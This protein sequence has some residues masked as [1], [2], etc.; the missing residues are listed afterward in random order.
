[1]AKRGIDVG[2]EITGSAKGF[3]SAA[4]D[5]QKATAALKS[6]ASSDSKGIAAAF[7]SMGGAIGRAV[8]GI[9]AAFKALLANPIALA[10]TAIVGVLGGLLKAFKSTDKGATEFAARF[11]QVKAIIDVVRQRLVSVGEAIGH[12]FKGEWK[13]AGASFKEAVT[14]IGDQLK[15]AT[16]AAREYAYAIDAIGDSESNYVSQS[17]D[18]RNKIA[19]LEFSAQDKT[20]SSS[21][22]KADLKEAIGL[23]EQEAKA[24]QDLARRKLDTEIKYL[25]DKNNIRSEDILAF[26]RMTDLEQENASDALKNLRN[27][28]EDKFA[29]IEKLYAGWIDADTT[30]YEQNKRNI[31]KL[32][33]FE[34]EEIRKR[35]DALKK[36]KATY[37]DVY[38]IIVKIPT[39][40]GLGKVEKTTKGARMARGGKTLAGVTTEGPGEDDLKIFTSLGELLADTTNKTILLTNAFA[41]LGDTIEGVA[42]GGEGAMKGMVTAILESI[43]QIIGAYLSQA[44]AATIKD[45]TKYPFPISLAMAAIGVAAITGLW[46]SKVPSFAQGGM[47]P[48]GYPND[49]FP[50]LLSSGEKIIPSSKMSQ[51]IHLT[52][53]PIRIEGKNL[54][55]PIRRMSDYITG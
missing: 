42:A 8:K 33:T 31:S 13:E 36:L 2:V 39:F 49:T 32:T 18:I 10:L 52:F 25:A 24:H 53:D 16:R 14:G 50:A 34:Q 22:R 15:E 37:G 9:S 19:K 38:S 27:N 12:V 3:K 23:S 43:R 29:E 21:A 40:A 47:V 45:S 55:I 30:F 41:A 48:A 5:A 20:R 6:K 11:E 44:I 26:I 1:M 35:E 4:E 7:Q 17:A 46:K 28:Y 51:T 54:V